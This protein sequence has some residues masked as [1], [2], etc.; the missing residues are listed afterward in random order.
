MTS[1]VRLLYRYVCF[2]NKGIDDINISNIVHQKSVTTNIPRY[3]NLENMGI[4][5]RGVRKPI[6]TPQLR[7]CWISA[8]EPPADNGVYGLG[9]THVLFSNYQSRADITQTD[10]EFLGTRAPLPYYFS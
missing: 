9:K 4:K 10:L 1:L 8:L 6:E 2:A 5:G 3:S 7:H